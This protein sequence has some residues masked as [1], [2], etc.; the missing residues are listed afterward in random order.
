MGRREYLPTG[1]KNVS[2]TICLQYFRLGATKS[3]STS[4]P[5]DLCLPVDSRWGY[6]VLVLACLRRGPDRFLFLFFLLGRR[7]LPGGGT[8]CFFFLWAGQAFRCFFCL[9]CIVFSGLFFFLH[10]LRRRKGEQL[11]VVNKRRG[12]G[13]YCHSTSSLSIPLSRIQELHKGKR[14]SELQGFFGWI[15]RHAPAL[16]A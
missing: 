9:F 16:P 2:T 5:F 3:Q 13:N 6:F 7:P 4:Q 12:T 10:L 15:D 11:P 8:E 1:L 14:V